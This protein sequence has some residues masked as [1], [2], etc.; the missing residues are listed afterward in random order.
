MKSR[1][2]SEARLRDLATA[3]D[4]D[5]M[6]MGICHACLSFVS[7]PLADGDAARARSQARR[8][9]PILW[10]EGLEEPALASLRQAHEAGVQDAEAALIDVELSGGRSAIVR[11]IVLRLAGDLARRAAHEDELT[12]VARM[13]VPLSPPGLN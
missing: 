11:S 13:R 9:A 8:M 3:L 4:L 2:L 5:V 6:S 12:A 7:F 10:E 1:R